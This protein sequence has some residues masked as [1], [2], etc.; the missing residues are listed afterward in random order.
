MRVWIEPAEHNEDTDG[1]RP[2]VQ[3][4]VQTTSLIEDKEVRG[5]TA[6][7]SDQPWVLHW[8]ISR[9]S[10]S[11]EEKRANRGAAEDRKVRAYNL[12]TG[13]DINAMRAVWDQID[14]GKKG[15]ANGGGEIQSGF[16]PTSF[17]AASSNVEK[18][19][20][21]SRKG[22]EDAERIEIRMQGRPKVILGDVLGQGVALR[23]CAPPY[24]VVDGFRHWTGMVFHKNATAVSGSIQQCIETVR[25]SEN[26]A[27]TAI[28]I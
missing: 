26:P 14:Y 17:K 25:A 10:V 16:D 22:K 13:M 23:G 21:L 4:D 6:V 11:D 1:P 15:S 2:I 5:S 20:A 12:P 9:S 3:L 28:Q 8:S 27:L 18:L 7:S 19:R 24:T